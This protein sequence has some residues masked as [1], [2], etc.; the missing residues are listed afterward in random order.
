MKQP[1]VVPRAILESV[2][3]CSDLVAARG[4][5]EGVV[6]LRLFVTEPDRHLFYRVGDSMLLIFNPQ[7]TQSVVSS[8]NGQAIP[9][10]GAEGASHFAFAVEA[11]EMMAVKAN[12]QQHAIE[13]EAEID[14]PNGAHSIYCRDPAGNSVEF[15][16]RSLWFHNSDATV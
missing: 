10:H 7:K 4:F 9:L 3:Y 14:W 12:L 15:A 13:I 11:D 8:V 6:G 1:S 2:I 5:Y 16:T